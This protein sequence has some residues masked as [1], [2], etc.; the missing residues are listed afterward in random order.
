MLLDYLTGLNLT[1]ALK[2]KLT[3][4]N[5]MDLILNIF[6]LILTLNIFYVNNILIGV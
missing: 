3:Q 4:R 6:S 2:T 5:F 1:G